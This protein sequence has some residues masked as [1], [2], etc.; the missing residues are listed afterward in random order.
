MTSTITFAPEWFRRIQNV[1]HRHE[2]Y[3][4][5]RNGSDRLTVPTWVLPALLAIP[6]V[7][8]ISD[9]EHEQRLTPARELTEME[10]RL[11]GY[12]GHR[13]GGWG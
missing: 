1:L 6:T 7:V 12:E 5:V 3:P 11:Y 13:S 2:A 10:E 4:Y 9:P 8:V